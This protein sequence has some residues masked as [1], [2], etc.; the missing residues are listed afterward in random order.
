[1]ANSRKNQAKETQVSDTDVVT[2]VPF[3]T[4]DPD[5][6]IDPQPVD[7]TGE[8]LPAPSDFEAPVDPTPAPTPAPRAEK[9][10]I[11]HEGNLTKAMLTFA[12][13]QGT[14][15]DVST[16]QEAYRAVPT[17]TR[18]KAQGIAMKASMDAGVGMDKLGVILV[19]L[20]NLPTAT[21]ATRTKVEVDPLI[22]NSQKLSALMRLFQTRSEVYGEEAY[23]LTLQWAD[24]NSTAKPTTEQGAAISKL[25]EQLTKVIDKTSK[26][27]STVRTQLTETLADLVTRGA[28]TAGS[29]LTGA[30]DAKGILNADGSIQT[31]NKVF[32]NP[33][34]AARAHRVDPETGKE[35]S[36][37]GWDFWH[38]GEVTIGSL[39]TK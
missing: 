23:N 11:D 19:A 16:L 38:F 31:L 27:G 12:K 37:N 17:G 39:R 6:P 9:V 15:E 4:E 5:G 13:S 33:S 32:D 35:T 8:P 1:M 14:A 22:A 21:K 20:N 34:A 2:E 26:S 30:G 10:V 18:G 29:E 3:A 24:E 36:T 28:L 7:V 25:V